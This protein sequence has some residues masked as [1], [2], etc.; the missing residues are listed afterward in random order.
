MRLQELPPV[1]I[2]RQ[3]VDHDIWTL[4]GILH[5][6]VIDWIEANGLQALHPDY[7]DEWTWEQEWSQGTVI[8]ALVYIRDLNIRTMFK[9]AWGGV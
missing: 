9:L 1:H 2:G 5:Q 6:E 7:Q 8:G 4:N 3:H